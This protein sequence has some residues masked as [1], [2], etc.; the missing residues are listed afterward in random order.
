MESK[1]EAGTEAG[2]CFAT[3]EVISLRGFD[4]FTV[5]IAWICFTVKLHIKRMY[6][7]CLQVLSIFYIVCGAPFIS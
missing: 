4:A 3:T 7:K 6:T 2:D 5:L 1:R